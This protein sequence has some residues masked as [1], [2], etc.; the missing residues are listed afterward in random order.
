MKIQQT[1]QTKLFDALNPKFF[2][3][4]NESHMHNVPP[5]SETHFKIVMVSNDFEGLSL[6]KR[7]QLVYKILSKE[8]KQGI[9]AL[10]LHTL[11]ESEYEKRLGTIPSS[12]LCLG[13]NK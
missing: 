3:V 9:H 10:A 8:M 13:G 1:I 5:G 4:T 7:H 2:A 6:L 11:T 12:P